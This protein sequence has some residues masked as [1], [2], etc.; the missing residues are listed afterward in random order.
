MLSWGRLK[1]VVGPAE[2]GGYWLIG[3]KAAQP[4]LFEN[5]SWS[6]SSVFEQTMER[7][8]AAGLKTHVLRKLPDI[9]TIEDL[10]RFQS[11]LGQP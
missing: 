3:L 9:D 5:I 1:T 4:A 10:R 7:A 8:K 11:R 6:S 2:D